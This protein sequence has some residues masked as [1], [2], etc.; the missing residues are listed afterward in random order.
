MRKSKVFIMS[1]TLIAVA[2]LPAAAQA[3]TSW[4]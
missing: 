1:V 4:T 3:G 2:L